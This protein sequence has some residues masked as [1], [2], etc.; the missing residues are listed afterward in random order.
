ML[1]S[2]TLSLKHNPA[3]IAGV[4]RRLADQDD[5]RVVVVSEGVGAE[6]LKKVKV[7]QGLNN[8]L[9]FPFQPYDRFSE[10]L[11]AASVLLAI[12]E[13]DAGVFRSHR[14]C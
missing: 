11:G 9:L 10:V 13:P 2:G 7:E 3:S 8:L 1:Y 12:I 4:A 6:W 14:R 5:V